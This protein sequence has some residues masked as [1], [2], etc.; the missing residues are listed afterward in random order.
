LVSPAPL[1]A[2]VF[3]LPHNRKYVMTYSFPFSLP[4]LLDVSA[5]PF[6]AVFKAPHLPFPSNSSFA[7]EVVFFV[8]KWVLFRLFL[9]PL[10]HKMKRL[11]TFPLQ[12]GRRE[13]GPFSAH[14]VSPNLRSFFSLRKRDLPS[15][16]SRL[17]QA[18][19]LDCALEFFHS[20]HSFF[21][22]LISIARL[23]L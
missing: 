4:F 9:F 21:P 3:P 23:G 8:G 20:R 13:A 5:T 19:S 7:Q 14:H 22:F 18:F 11:V 16:G 1:K 17:S 2:C 10:P 15:R 6:F 12:A